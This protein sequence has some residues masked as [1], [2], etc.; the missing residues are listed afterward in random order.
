ML[1]SLLNATR[2]VARCADDQW[3]RGPLDL[4]FLVAC[5]RSPS[6]CFVLQLCHHSL[7]LFAVSPVAATSS[8]RRLRGNAEFSAKAALR[9]S[10]WSGVL[11]A[12]IRGGALAWCVASEVASAGKKRKDGYLIAGAHALGRQ[13]MR[14]GTGRD[15]VCEKMRT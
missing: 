5:V 7:T 8:R 11:R 1:L 6:L 9:N 15:D 13:S 2:S 4:V 12:L 14:A 3:M 10:I